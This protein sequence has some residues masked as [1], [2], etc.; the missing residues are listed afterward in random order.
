[1][2]EVDDFSK[3]CSSPVR[4]SK[5]KKSEEGEVSDDVTAADYIIADFEKSPVRKIKKVQK[6]KKK[7][8]CE[9]RG[10]GGVERI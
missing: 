7:K 8:A 1:M 5:K 4:K 10:G 9:R 3:L 6:I 2:E